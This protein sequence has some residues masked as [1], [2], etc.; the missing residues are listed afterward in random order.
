MS[1]KITSFFFFLNLGTCWNIS[2][3]EC[4]LLNALLCHM[5]HLKG[6]LYAATWSPLYVV[7]ICGGLGI[8]HVHKNDTFEGTKMAM[9]VQKLECAL[10]TEILLEA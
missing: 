8:V 2:P 3:S 10:I 5:N 4:Y 7:N 1:T 6:R 9:Q